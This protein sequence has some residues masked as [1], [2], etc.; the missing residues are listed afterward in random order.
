MRMGRMEREARNRLTPLHWLTTVVS[1]T[2]ILGIGKSSGSPSSTSSLTQKLVIGYEPVLS[3]LQTL[4]ILT[5]VNN[6]LSKTEV[7]SK[8]KRKRSRTAS[9]ISTDEH[10]GVGNSSKNTGKIGQAKVRKYIES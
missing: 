5:P 4:P 6:S 7:K 10:N 9:S 8:G 1:I 3:G 2:C